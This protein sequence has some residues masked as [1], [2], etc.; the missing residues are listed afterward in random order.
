MRIERA[1]PEDAGKV[2]EIIDLC[3]RQMQAAGSDQWND[4]YPNLEIVQE[5]ANAGNLYTLQ[6]GD[7]EPLAGAI[8][9]NEAQSPEYSKVA[10]R[11]QSA[12]VLVIHRLCVRPDF[13]KNGAARMLMDF[14]EAFALR[15]GYDAVRLDTYTGNPRA[16]KLYLQRGYERAGQV[17]FRA[18]RLPFDC[19]EKA[20]KPTS[21]SCAV[22]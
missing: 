22:S 9:L 13:Q 7:G 10:W 16:V 21:C 4:F 6:L 14:A 20:V 11:Y 1:A 18:R 19:F 15:H 2:L 8:C 12:R 17:T 5:D 3:K